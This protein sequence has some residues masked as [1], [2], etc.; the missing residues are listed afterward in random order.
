MPAPKQSGSTEILDSKSVA[1]SVATPRPVGRERFIGI[2][3]GGTKLQLVVGTPAGA[4]LERKRFQVDRARGAE[5][6]REKIADAIIA[7]H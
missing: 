2:E 7:G 1:A 5:G 6:I 3:I 4:I